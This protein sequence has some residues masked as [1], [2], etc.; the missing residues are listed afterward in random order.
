MPG[1]AATVGLTVVAVTVGS[2]VNP[3]LEA[4]VGFT[5]AIGSSVIFTSSVA[6]CC[7]VMNGSSVMVDLAGTVGCSVTVGSAVTV[8]LT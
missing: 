1:L 6:I 2:V 8:T 7:F 3:G 5:V 4:T